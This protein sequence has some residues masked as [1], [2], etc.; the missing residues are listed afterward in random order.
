LNQRAGWAGGVAGLLVVLA[1]A[2]CTT[3]LELGERRY[4]EGDRLAALETWRA[5]PEDSLYHEAAQRRIAAVEDEFE[6]LVVRYEQR[7]RYFERKGRLAESILNWRLAAKL[8]PGNAE[9]ADHVQALSRTLA[10]RKGELEAAYAGD[11]ARRDFAAARAQLAQ[12]RT[13]DPFDAKLESDEREFEVALRGAVDE[14]LARGRAAYD[15]GNRT[16][17]SAAFREVLAIEPENETAQGLLSYAQGGRAG[18]PPTPGAPTARPARPRE[19]VT[20]REPPPPGPATDAQIRA[21]GFYQNAL[22]AERKGDLYAAIRQDQRALGADPKHAAARRHLA[23]MRERLAPEVEGLIES[24]R[25]SF[26][27]EDLQG[28]LDQWRRALLVDPDNARAQ[29]YVARAE[30]LLE[31]LEQLRAEPEGA[32]GGPR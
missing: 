8:A 26:R 29:G 19:P 20:P 15:A 32:G 28:A 25:T 2:G 13:L 4:R 14:R 23:A 17:A 1:L 24:G 31:N 3:P 6:Q 22:A 5:I 12:R 18:P 9:A 16:E 27:Q 7:A 30:K 11:F 10:A 21:E